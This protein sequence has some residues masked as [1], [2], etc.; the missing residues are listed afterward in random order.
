MASSRV[1]STPMTNERGAT[2]RY[3]QS[4]SLLALGAALALG[5][6]GCGPPRDKEYE[7]EE[8]R[9]GTLNLA[10]SPSPLPEARPARLRGHAGRVDDDTVEVTLAP[11]VSV[12]GN[13]VVDWAD[14]GVSVSGNATG[15]LDCELAVVVDAAAPQAVDVVFVLDTTGS[16]LWAIDGVKA[17][18]EAFLDT[19]EGFNINAEVGGIEFGD[20]VRTSV[21][22][23]DLGA[24][25]V[26]L[27]HMTA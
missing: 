7:F 12:E 3:D 26:W 11:L 6:Q 21:P 23:G 24:F 19:L 5:A 1:R 20:E 17:G 2:G 9:C 14:S 27:D 22:I 13:A 10:R 15:M 8:K 18:I 25:R 16:M 4:V